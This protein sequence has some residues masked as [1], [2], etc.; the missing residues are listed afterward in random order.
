MVV[1]ASPIETVEVVVLESDSPLYSLNVVSRLPRG[2]SCS[3][4]N[5]YDISLDPSPTRFR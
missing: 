4:F 3:V 5:G 2:S 1:E